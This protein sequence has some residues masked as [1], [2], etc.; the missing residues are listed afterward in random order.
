MTDLDLAW[1]VLSDARNR[2]V[3]GVSFAPHLERTRLSEALFDTALSRPWHYEW[4]SHRILVEFVSGVARSLN[5]APESILDPVCGYGMLLATSAQ[6]A[7]ARIVHGVDIQEHPL[8]FAAEVL[9]SSAT[10]IV[11]DYLLPNDR[12]LDKYDLIVA[13]PPHGVRLSEDQA[14]AVGLNTGFLDLDHGLVLWAASRLS[15]EGSALVTVSP[16]FFFTKTGKR[17]RELVAGSGCQI[18]SAI[19]I[20]RDLAQPGS[21]GPGGYLLL[22][23]RGQQG[24][25]F[26]GQ[27]SEDPENRNQLLSNLVRRK[28]KGPVAL[29]RFCS[30]SDFIGFEALAAQEGLKRLARTLGWSAHPAVSVFPLSERMR[31]DEDSMSE[32]ANSLYL[33]LRTGEAFKH[34]TEATET[35]GNWW[36][37]TKDL[38]HLKVDPEVAS[39]EFMVHWFNATRIGSLSLSS[40]SSRKAS[41]R[42]RELLASTIHL[43]SISDQVLFL[44]GGAYLGKLRAEAAELESQL[45]DGP[46]PVSETVERIRSLNQEDRYEDWLETLPFPLARVLWKHHAANSSYR[47]RYETLLHFF[48]AAAAFLSTVHLSAFMADDGLWQEVGPELNRKLQQQSLSLTQASFGSWKLVFELLGKR[49]EEMMAEEA[50][51]GEQPHVQQIFRVSDVRSLDVLTDPRLRSILQEA[52]KIRNDWHGHGGAMSETIAKDV[53]DRL[54]V[55]VQQM[56]EVFGRKWQALELIQPGASVYSQEVFS[57]TSSRLMGTRCNPFEKR[58]Y[59][60]EDPLETGGLYLFDAVSRRGLKLLPFVTVM[61]SPEQS[62]DACYVLSRAGGGGRPRWVSYHFEQESQIDLEVDGLLEALARFAEFTGKGS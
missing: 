59:E 47:E 21:D 62:A 16:S 5:P 11:G 53:H 46:E 32:D 12:L 24:E 35:S 3:H 41:L 52:N 48:E 22:L 39:S 57:V 36:V 27:L 23:Q 29:G 54:E 58:V 55:L 45:W 4:Q 38:L 37:G 28:L 14:S 10:L 8:T 7:R 18:A 43:P 6:A 9:G 44:E 15:S 33:R 2:S 60:S 31:D 25:L 1:E 56:R 61:P 30:I 20:P 13:E 26:V 49:C 51:D 17:V 40:I 42:P 50:V 19:H 34:L